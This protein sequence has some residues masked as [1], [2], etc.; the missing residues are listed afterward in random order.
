[1]SK[2]D[3]YLTNEWIN[4]NRPDDGLFRVYWTEDNNAS[5]E[6]TGLSVRYEWYYKDG[7]RADGESKGWWSNGQIKHTWTWK[8]GKKNGLYTFWYENGQKSIEGKYKDD[9]KEGLYIFHSG[10]GH[11]EHKGIFK[12]DKRDGLWTYWYPNGQ[13]KAER[14]FKDE[15]E[16]LHTFWYENGQIRSAKT[17]KDSSYWGFLRDYNKDD[18]LKRS[19][20]RIENIYSH[21]LHSKTSPELWDK[22]K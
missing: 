18:L 21:E 19:D 6:D 15:K 4:K 22:E 14:L 20:Y 10:D 1:M 5:F 17:F 7:E 2:V 11:L 8:N 9:K 13:K 16:E 3:G 12:D